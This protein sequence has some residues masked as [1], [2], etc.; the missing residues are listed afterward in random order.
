MPVADQLQAR[1]SIPPEGRTEY[2]ANGFLGVMKDLD[3]RFILDTK[4]WVMF[5]ASFGVEFEGC[6]DIKDMKAPPPTKESTAE[7]NTKDSYYKMM[8]RQSGTRPFVGDKGYMGLVPDLTEKGDVIV[9][10]RGAKFPYVLRK[11]VNGKHGGKY[12]LVGEAYVHGV[13][14]GEYD[15]EEP[16]WHSFGLI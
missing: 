1:T 4:M 10:F 3:K 5:R 12:E 13:M 6:K 8:D 2:L 11:K 14:Y 16:E 9:I 15:A 7:F